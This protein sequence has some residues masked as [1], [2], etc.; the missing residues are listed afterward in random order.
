MGV[1]RNKQNM[2]CA[3]GTPI[4]YEDW[5]VPLAD[6]HAFLE[7]QFSPQAGVITLKLNPKKCLLRIFK[8]T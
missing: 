8:F 4:L 3:H 2:F 5:L 7:G 1:V 6:I